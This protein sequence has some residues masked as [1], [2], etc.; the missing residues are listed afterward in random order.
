MVCFVVRRHDEGRNPR[1]DILL[2]SCAFG[3]E[4]RIPDWLQER[5]G[6]LPP[7]TPI[8]LN[9]TFNRWDEFV[10]VLTVGKPFRLNLFAVNQLNWRACLS[11]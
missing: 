9:A 2:I 1:T 6:L 5:R 4:Q 10:R 3:S 11:A 7:N 8:M